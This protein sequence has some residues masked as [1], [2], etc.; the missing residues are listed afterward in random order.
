MHWTFI[1]VIDMNIIKKYYYYKNI[2][3]MQNFQLLVDSLLLLV[4]M[5][6]GVIMSLWLNNSF[7]FEMLNKFGVNILK[8]WWNPKF[9]VIRRVRFGTNIAVLGFGLIKEKL[10]PW[11]CFTI[12]KFS[13][14]EIIWLSAK[15]LFCLCDELPFYYVLQNPFISWNAQKKS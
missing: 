3:S 12:L 7:H 9:I 8:Y 14:S 11:L 5:L 13:W 15:R 4:C 2:Y 10:Y 1:L 6:M